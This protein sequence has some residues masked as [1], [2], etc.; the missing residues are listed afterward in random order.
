[1]REKLDIPNLKTTDEPDAVVETLQA[2]VTSLREQNETLKDEKA[3]LLA[4]AEDGKVYRTARI[5]EGI[6]QGIRCA[7]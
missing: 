3:D 6:K 7:R 5:A 4:D 1:M 2:E